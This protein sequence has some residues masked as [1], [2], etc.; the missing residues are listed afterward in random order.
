MQIFA[1]YICI[2][3]F[4][5]VPLQPILAKGQLSACSRKHL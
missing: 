4:F 5:F 3:V 2:Y 1:T